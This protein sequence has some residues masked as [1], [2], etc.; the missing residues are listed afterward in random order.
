M[1]LGDIKYCQQLW[2]S[3][4]RYHERALKQ[5]RATVGEKHISTADARYK[6]ALHAV[7]KN[8]PAQLE[9]A[10]CVSPLCLTS[11]VKIENS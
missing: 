1:A 3:S 8:Q 11:P 5:F 10:R 4:Q 9:Y 2:D 7:R 6:V